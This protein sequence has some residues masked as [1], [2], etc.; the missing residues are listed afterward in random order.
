MDLDEITDPIELAK[1]IDETFDMI[2]SLIKLVKLNRVPVVGRIPSVGCIH[3]T[4]EWIPSSR[5]LN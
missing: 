4:V 5:L 1:L 2:N 3:L